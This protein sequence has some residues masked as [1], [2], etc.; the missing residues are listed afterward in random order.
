MMVMV[1]GPA[2]G[3]SLNY[4]EGSLQNQQSNYIAI[5]NMTGKMR[6]KIHEKLKWKL[7]I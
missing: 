1:V 2:W 6:A 4:M 3:P 5:R 7:A